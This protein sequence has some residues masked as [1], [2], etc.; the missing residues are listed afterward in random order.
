MV[1]FSRLRVLDIKFREHVT[2]GKADI[3]ETL[4]RERHRIY[5]EVISYMVKD[6]LD[7]AV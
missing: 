3:Y 2:V 7:K 5:Q 1:T 6:V 4:S